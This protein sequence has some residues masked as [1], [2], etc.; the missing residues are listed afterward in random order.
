MLIEQ[1][2][3]VFMSSCIKTLIKYVYCG[4]V[5]DFHIVSYAEH[6]NYYKTLSANPRW[7]FMYTL[8]F[9]AKCGRCRER[10]WTGAYVAEFLV[11][12]FYC[13]KC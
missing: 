5:I 6:L 13:H 10:N 12:I 7:Y 2:V 8:N 1:H 9:V 11:S 3:V 4:R